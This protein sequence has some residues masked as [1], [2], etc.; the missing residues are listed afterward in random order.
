HTFDG[1]GDTVEIAWFRSSSN[2]E[3]MNHFVMVISEEELPA[4]RRKIE[5]QRRLAFPRKLVKTSNL[6]ENWISLFPKEDY[7]AYEAKWRAMFHD[8]VCLGEWI[9]SENGLKESE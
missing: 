8:P 9:N 2:V 1:P 4:K 5:H 3:N 6:I 7:P